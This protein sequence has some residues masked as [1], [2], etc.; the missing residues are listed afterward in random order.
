MIAQ[1]KIGT[2]L[3][4]NICYSTEDLKTMVQRMGFGQNGYVRELIGH[5]EV[6]AVNSEKVGLPGF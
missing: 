1:N 3:S 5:Q 4:Y 2:L 6:P